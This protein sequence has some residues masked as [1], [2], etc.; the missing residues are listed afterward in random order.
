MHDGNPLRLW[1]CQIEVTGASLEQL[2][3][4]ILSERHLWDD[5]LLDSKVLQHPDERTQLFQIVQAE[6]SP[7]P[8]RDYCV[9]R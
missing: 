5:D 9:L 7:H 2:A 8:T 4:R 6:M 1:R 3:E